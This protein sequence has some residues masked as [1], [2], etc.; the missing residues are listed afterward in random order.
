MSLNQNIRYGP[1]NIKNVN[2]PDQLYPFIKPSRI[3]SG[4]VN[5]NDET[6]GTLFDYFINTTTSDFFEKNSVGTWVLI[7]NF[8]TGGGSVG[9]TNIE[10]ETPG[11]FKNIIGSTAH[12]KG[13]AGDVVANEIFVDNADADTVFLSIEPSYKPLTLSNVNNKYMGGDTLNPNGLIGIAEGAGIGSMWGQPP[14]NVWICSDPATSTWILATAGIGVQSIVNVGNSE[15][16]IYQSVD[17]GGIASLRSILGT[18][19]EIVIERSG[20]NLNVIASIDDN[21]KPI[22]LNKVVNVL[23]NFDGSQPAPTVNDDSSAG[24][25]VGSVWSSGDLLYICENASVGAAV[26]SLANSGQVSLE[27]DLYSVYVDG[28]SLQTSFSGPNVSTKLNV[29]VSI[30]SAVSRGSWASDSLGFG[31]VVTRTLPSNGLT[32]NKYLVTYSMEIFSTITVA[33]DRIYNIVFAA[34]DGSTP[35]SGH[36]LGSSNTF[37]FHTSSEYATLGGSFIFS[38][39]TNLPESFFPVIIS[40]VATADPIF[41]QLL[42]ITITEV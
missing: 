9:I 31:A 19:N 20:D 17:V 13:L 8:D 7:Y 18:S 36:I 25:Q 10:N 27:D 39:T 42:N 16:N 6:D 22:T 40:R 37:V 5:P 11:L 21:Y 2:N 23:N 12:F 28:P 30:P 26:W 29:G 1:Y 15:G 38:T 34:G 41:L 35:S 32:T 24:Y 14:S 4:P 3:L 33:I